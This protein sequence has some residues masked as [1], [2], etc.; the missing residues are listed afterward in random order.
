M[1]LIQNGNG[2]GN[3][4]NNNNRANHSGMNNKLDRVLGLLGDGANNNEPK[5]IEMT[6]LKKQILS[7]PQEVLQDNI[8]HSSR[9]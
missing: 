1:V 8:A 9:L 3:G 4:N 7:V 2:N 6:T 5:W